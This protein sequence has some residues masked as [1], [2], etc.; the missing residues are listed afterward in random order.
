MSDY[1]DVVFIV[2]GD[3]AVRESLRFVIELDGIDVRTC[4]SCKELLSHPELD[5]GC[6]AVVDGKTLAGDGADIIARLEMGLDV[7]PIVLIADHIGRRRFRRAIGAGLFHVVDQPV[8]DDALLR[9]I[10]AIRNA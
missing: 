7:L 5:A 2:D 10:R 1:R 6:C 8:L 9:C 3:Y 4:S